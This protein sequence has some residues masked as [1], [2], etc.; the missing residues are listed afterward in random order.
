VSDA[1]NREILLGLWKVHIL[2]HAGERPV[3]GN[4]LL[5]E[6]REHG[7]AISPGTLYPI[8]HRMEKHGWLKSKRP[9]GT[10]PRAQTPYSLTREGRRVLEELR[11]FIAELDREL[12]G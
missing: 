7:Y 4:W 11:G 3:V 5:E 12:R 10:G 9:A 8:L 2:F 6:L 1:L